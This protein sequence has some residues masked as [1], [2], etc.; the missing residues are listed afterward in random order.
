MDHARGIEAEGGCG[1]G[2]RRADCRQ[3]SNE[4]KAEMSN[5]KVEVEVEDGG[6]WAKVVGLAL[7][8]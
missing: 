2:C 7:L 8:G 6:H 4:P 5:R 1:C 3:L